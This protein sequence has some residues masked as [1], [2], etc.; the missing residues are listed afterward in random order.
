[1]AS[2]VWGQH[3]FNNLDAEQ[4][5]QLLVRAE[6]GKGDEYECLML[7]KSSTFHL[8]YTSNSQAD[9]R[10]GALSDAAVGELQN[11]LADP[12]LAELSQRRIQE[13]LLPE[14]PPSGLGLSIHRAPGADGWQNLTFNSA[15]SQG[16]F[17]TELTPFLKWFT[18]LKKEPH[19]SLPEES[20]RNN[21]LL[22]KPELKTRAKPATAASR[23]GQLQTGLL[24][25]VIEEQFTLGS[26]ER[27][28]AVVDTKGRYRAETASR[29]AGRSMQAKVVED[30]LSET[31]LAELIRLLSDPELAASQ[32]RN[33]P[34]N[35]GVLD[36]DLLSVYIQRSGG[37]QTLEFSTFD[38]GPGS[39]GEAQ[40][41]SRKDLRIIQP[42]RQWLRHDLEKRAARTNQDGIANGCLLLH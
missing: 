15:A 42:I 37:P 3:S 4:A 17:K 39:Q 11:V 35:I 38:A 22:G 31:E 12:A 19:T 26:S 16:P 33:R 30:T 24:F 28:C 40:S 18:S 5:D 6:R 34:A 23:G 13:P 8:E 10:E 36:A 14:E 2:T 20:G 9:I 25:R 1:M 29:R 27:R 41:D 32:H 7:R 21:C